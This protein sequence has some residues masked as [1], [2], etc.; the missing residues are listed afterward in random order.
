M[1]TQQ[2]PTAPTRAQLDQL[3]RSFSG[4][5][6]G[7]D[8]PG[9]DD[10]RRVWNAV[11]DRRPALVVRPL[12][13][14]DVVAAVRF[15]RERELEISVRGGGHSAVG[16]S[17]SEGGLVIDLGRM[18]EVSVDPAT[19]RARTGG[20]ALLGQLDVAGQE[21][22]LVCPVGVVGH[23]GVAGL[24]LGGGVGRLQRKFGLT[25]DN[26]RAVE[27]VTVDGRFV[28]A[29]ETEEPE[30]FWGLRGA[31]ANFGV[32]TALEF[33]LQPF[34][35]VLY[36]SARVHPASD[37][38]ELWPIFREFA[39][40]APDAVSAIFGIGLA[41]PA[42]DYPDSIAGRPI[43]VVS[44]NYS[45]L[46]EDLERDV[47]RLLQGPEPAQ[48]TAG[49]QQYLEVQSSADLSMAWGGRSFI[50]GGNIAD[51]S[52]DVLDGF[53]EH[54]ARAAGE[55]SISITALGGAIGRVADDA[56]AYTGR[57][58]PFD[59]SADISWPDASG[60]DAA[61]TWVREAMAIVDDDLLPGRYVNELS[62][63]SPEM[64]RSTYGDAKLERLRALKRA[65]D[66]TNVFHLNHN[67]A[68]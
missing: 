38:H 19:R 48:V 46:A 51:A 53:V 22:G 61:A 28:R 41:E 7:P 37:I 6:I 13:V 29:S 52:P 65:W 10:A 23:T 40:M 24:T 20:G 56:M 15:G 47:A 12:N 59:V 18:N 17:T 3:T 54:A 2:Q 50:L 45:G 63:A 60:D 1:T 43:V 57:T 16:H 5:I 34:S 30:L 27:L 25:I 4:E 9:Y 35:G 14:D 8:A 64:T 68:P 11:F 55:G 44:Y 49:P 21:H 58:A 32:A 66:P 67:I 62:D 26:L 33:E 31:G 42:S 36:R 39:A